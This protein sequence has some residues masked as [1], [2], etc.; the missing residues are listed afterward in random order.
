MPS[1]QTPRPKANQRPRY[2][3]LWVEFDPAGLDRNEVIR[4]LRLQ[5]PPAVAP[6]LTRYDG[7]FGILRVARGEET[8]A[9]RE[10]ERMTGSLSARPLSTSGTIAGLERRHRRSLRG[11]G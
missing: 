4:R 5:L 7:R 6:W 1:R 11:N 2:R 3:Y 8:M 10:L 9:R